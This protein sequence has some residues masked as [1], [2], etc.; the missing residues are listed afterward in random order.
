[1][2]RIPKHELTSSYYRI[3]GCITECMLRSDEDNQH[4][5]GGYAEV[6]SPSSNVKD[7]DEEESK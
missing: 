7:T 1:M 4:V 3:V 2:K 6:T 5:H